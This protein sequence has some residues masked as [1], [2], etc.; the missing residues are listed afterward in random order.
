MDFHAAVERKHGCLSGNVMI[1]MRR[2]IDTEYWR[3]KQDV[4]KIKKDIE[5]RGHEKLEKLADKANARKL[6]EKIRRLTEGFKTEVR[7]DMTQRGHI[8][9]DAQI[10]LSTSPA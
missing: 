4:Q 6:Y 5:A 10:I 9:T 8:V 7:S 3:Q 1:N 2:G